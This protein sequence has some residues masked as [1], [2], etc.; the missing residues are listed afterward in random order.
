MSTPKKKAGSVFAVLVVI[1]LLLV[2]AATVTVNV[3]FSGDRIPEVFG[4]YL[5]LHEETDMEPDIPQ[6]S[7]VFAKNSPNTSL[8]PVQRCCAIWRTTMLRCG[9]FTRSP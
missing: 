1:V 5:Y 9:I 7:L 2:V 8:P 4:Y 3:I 6:N